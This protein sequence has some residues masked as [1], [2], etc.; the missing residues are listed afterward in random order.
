MVAL[1]ERHRLVCLPA[2]RLADLVGET[3]P[4]W[5]GK[6]GS[7]G[8]GPVVRDPGQLM[9]LITLGRMVAVVPES[10]RGRRH[11]GLTCRPVPDAPVATI[12]IA[13]PSGS[14]SPHVTAFVHAATAAPQ[15]RGDL[16]R[17]QPAC[18]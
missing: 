3:M 8:E 16:Q 9:Q 4:R 10:V 7:N 11:V 18:R 14:A 13:W 17:D 6:L 12:V 2:V 15:R 5:P 1:P